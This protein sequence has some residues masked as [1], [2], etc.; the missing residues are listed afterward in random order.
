MIF[1]ILLL[2]QLGQ[3]SRMALHYAGVEYQDDAYGPDLSWDEHKFKLGLDFPN[4]PYYIDDEVKLSQSGAI[5]RHIGRKN[6]L[7]GKNASENATID[8]LI[9]TATDFKLGLAK[10]AYNPDFVR[11]LTF[12]QKNLNNLQINLIF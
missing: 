12:Y 11:L 5:L 9:E 10:I 6:G 2:F 3:A 7:Y 8:M 1:L 4:L